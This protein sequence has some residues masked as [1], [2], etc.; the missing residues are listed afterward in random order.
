[1]LCPELL[2]AYLL[3]LILITVAP[4]LIELSLIEPPALIEPRSASQVKGGLLEEFFSHPQNQKSPERM[5][6]S[7][8]PSEI[9]PFIISMRCC[10]VNLF[11][12][13]ADAFLALG[14]HPK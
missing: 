14:F 7:I 6:K 3:L 9:M 13:T 8:N 1:M 12:P 2:D 11:F 4:A 5:E 10:K